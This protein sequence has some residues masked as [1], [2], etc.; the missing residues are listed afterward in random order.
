MDPGLMIDT[1]RYARRRMGVRNV[2]VDHLGFVMPDH[3]DDRER[4]AI[5]QVVR[6]LSILGEHEGMTIFLVVHPSNSKFRRGRVTM[7]DLKGASA[8]RQDAH[9]VWIVEKA[10]PTKKRQYPGAFI[11]FDKVRSDWASS[12]GKVFLAFDPISLNYA[13]TWIQTPSGRKGLRLGKGMPRSGMIRRK[14]DV[15]EE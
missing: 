13:D 10:L 14:A 5:E 6:E 1:I 2:L 9:E 4:Q 11:H 12:G 3:R 8:I 15:I 7:H